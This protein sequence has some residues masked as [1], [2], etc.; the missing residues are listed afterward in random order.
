MIVVS[1]QIE[2]FLYW[3]NPYSGSI[4]AIS[5]IIAAGVAIYLIR[6]TVRAAKASAISAKAAQRQIELMMQP[7]AEVKSAKNEAGQEFRVTI[8]NAGKGNLIVLG[9]S[10]VCREGEIEYKEV[11]P[12]VTKAFL[13]PEQ[14]IT[15]TFPI[16]SLEQRFREAMRRKSPMP[17]VNADLFFIVDFQEPTS[18]ARVVVEHSHGSGVS[19]II[20]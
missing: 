11:S 5:S 6:T 2:R 14:S 4:Q 18:G 15:T 3:L 9:L 8:R 19:R 17:S 20:G 12:A 13:V 10:I 7:L 1:H 16:L